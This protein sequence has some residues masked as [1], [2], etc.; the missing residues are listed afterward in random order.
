MTS[1]K[2]FH[3]VQ[4]FNPKQS[5]LKRKQPRA[6]CDRT[7]Q[8]ETKEIQILSNTLVQLNYENSKSEKRVIIFNAPTSTPIKNKTATQNNT[9]LGSRNIVTG[10]KTI[11]RRTKS[12]AT[13]AQQKQNRSKENSRIQS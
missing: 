9:L 3:L 13:D 2:A 6:A 11:P 1:Q 7:T 10:V 8:K 12:T 5:R 4:N